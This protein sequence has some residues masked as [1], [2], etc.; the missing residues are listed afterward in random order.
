MRINIRQTFVIL[1]LIGIFLMTI[2]PVADPDFWWHLRTGQLIAETGAIPHTDPFSL[3]FS[4]KSWTAHEWLSELFIYDLYRLGGFV[5]LILAF[6]LI[7]TAAFY[8]VYRRSPRNAYLSGFVLLL[9]AIATA[10]TWGIRPQ[11]LTFLFSSIFLFLL[12]RYYEKRELKWLIPLPILTILWVNLHAGYAMG[13]GIIAV[14]LGCDFLEWLWYQATGSEKVFGLRT[15]LPVG[16]VFLVSLLGVMLNP[17]GARMYIYPFETLTSPSMQQYIQEWFSPDFHQTIWQPLAWIL[18]ILPLL[19]IAGRSARIKLAHAALLFLF[20]YMALRSM[21]NVP[22]FILAVVPVMAELAEAAF[23]T[24]RQ[25]LVAKLPVSSTPP[26][27][28]PR[29]LNVALIAFALLA[30]AGRFVLIAQEQSKTEQEKFPAAAVDWILENHPA[31]NI[32]NTYGWG[33]YLIWRLPDYPVFIDGRADLYGD[34][35]IETYLSTYNAQ[36]GWQEQ[37]QTYH[38]NL[39]LAETGSGITNALIQA[40]DWKLVFS[41][42]N[43]M[44]FQKR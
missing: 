27:A 18:L 41:D 44:L 32:Y 9:G 6:S 12:D 5:L 40:T 20:G 36:T 19:A 16:M 4:G 43:S 15:V 13:P 2:R 25:Q 17:N 22:L 26:P 21:R 11:M 24:L 14:Y 7:I 29:I 38:V 23:N 42:E 35:F 10:P 30:V 39:V 37:L 28:L 34:S 3:T 8:L 1:L 33:G 31:G